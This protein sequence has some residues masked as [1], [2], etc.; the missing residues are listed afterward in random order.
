MRLARYFGGDARSELHL[1][2]TY[3]LCV[4][5]IAKTRTIDR[6]VLPPAG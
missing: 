4:A 5:Q 3:D 6:K 1:Q 2:V